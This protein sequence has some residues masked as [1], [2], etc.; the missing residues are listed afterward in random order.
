M[1][2]LTEL[3]FE[4]NPAVKQLLLRR[5]DTNDGEE[6]SEDWSSSRGN[7]SI[8]REEDTDQFYRLYALYH[9]RSLLILDGQKVEQNE[10]QLATER[11]APRKYS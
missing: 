10:H 4:G 3:A 1:T 8:L 7:D 2:S 9:V 5:S 11:F 6:I